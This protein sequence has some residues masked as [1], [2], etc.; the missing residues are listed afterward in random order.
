MGPAT[1]D[2]VTGLMEGVTMAATSPGGGGGARHEGT[3]C[4]HGGDGV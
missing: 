2:W 1:S 4:R 3:M